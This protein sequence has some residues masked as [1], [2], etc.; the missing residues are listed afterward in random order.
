[1]WE[2]IKPEWAEAV[3]DICGEP[4]PPESPPMKTREWKVIRYESFAC[5]ESSG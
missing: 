1:M 2:R 4:V 5:S 3:K